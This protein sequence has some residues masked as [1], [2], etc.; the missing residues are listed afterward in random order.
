M[1]AL[2]LTAACWL[3]K[4]SIC[5][6][7]Q[8]DGHCQAQRYPADMMLDVT[9]GLRPIARPEPRFGHKPETTA[10]DKRSPEAQGIHP[11]GTSSEHENLEGCWR[12][13]QRHD[14]DGD[15]V[16]ALQPAL[17]GAGSWPSGGRGN[18]HRVRSHGST[19][20]EQAATA[21]PQ[22]VHNVA[23]Q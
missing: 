23:T 17:R 21:S 19:T 2:R 7:T 9:F 20:P 3:L 11:E 16:V 8:N 6:S 12:R 5:Q 13:Q 22:P 15:K 10:D 4:S 1:A 14:E 18:L